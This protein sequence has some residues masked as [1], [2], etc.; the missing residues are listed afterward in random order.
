M[1]EL[2]MASGIRILGRGLDTL[3]L[4][5]YPTDE[6]GDIVNVRLSEVLEKELTLYKE[7]AQELDEEVPTRWAFEGETLFM[8]DKGGSHF[9]WIL[10]CH[11][12]TVAG[13]RG[14]KVGLCGQVGFSSEFLWRWNA[15]PA[16]GIS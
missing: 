4:N 3:I 5:I 10:S 13:S 9:R 14:I 6:Q 1:D 8:K 11:Q 16:K 12:L 2:D 7:R 15:N